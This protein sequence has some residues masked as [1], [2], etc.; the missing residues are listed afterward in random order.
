MQ[1]LLYIYSTFFFYINIIKLVAIS[2]L[3]QKVAFVTQKSQIF[4]STKIVIF[5]S[6]L[7]FDMKYGQ[8]LFQIK[9]TT[10]AWILIQYNVFIRYGVD[11]AKRC[12]TLY[13]GSEMLYE[14]NRILHGF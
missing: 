9:Y 11:G 3:R 2:S 5:N 1:Y 13:Y 10:L 8:T 7:H 4:F 12:E 6:L 14:Q